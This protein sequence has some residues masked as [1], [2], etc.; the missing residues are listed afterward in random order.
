ML[1]EWVAGSSGIRN[2]VQRRAKS[3][4]REETL[5]DVVEALVTLS[6]ASA[7][8]SRASAPPFCRV[9]PELEVEDQGGYFA[10]RQAITRLLRSAPIH[11]ELRLSLANHALARIDQD[12]RH[13][14]ILVPNY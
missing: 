13:L 1:S 10:G 12:L 3:A 14:Q 4:F 2:L 8:F 7:A 5:V 11:E 6:H 9:E